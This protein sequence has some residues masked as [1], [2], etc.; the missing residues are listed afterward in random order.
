MATPA[1]DFTIE[2]IG[3]LADLD[4]SP[5]IAAPAPRTRRRLT[6]SASRHW[7][8]PTPSTRSRRRPCRPSADHRK[9]GAALPADGGYAEA[10]LEEFR[11]EGVD[12]EA[13]AARPRREGA[14]AFAAS[15]QALLARIHEKN[16]CLAGTGA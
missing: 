5:L 1:A 14:D 3:E 4:I 7:Q 10:V 8:R 6:R 16:T 15:W 11:R 9:V 12:G 2:H 13:L